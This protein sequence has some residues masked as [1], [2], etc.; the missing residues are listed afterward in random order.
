[1]RYARGLLTP[2]TRHLNPK[3]STF[4]LVDNIYINLY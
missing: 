4:D 2:D 1:M 3:N